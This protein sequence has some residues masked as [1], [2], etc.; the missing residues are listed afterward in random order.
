MLRGVTIKLLFRLG[1]L[2]ISY[3]TASVIR[4]PSTFTRI[5]RWSI[6]WLELER[7]LRFTSLLVFKC[8]E[9]KL[10]LFLLIFITFRRFMKLDGEK[11]DLLLQNG[12][13]FI[14]FSFFVAQLPFKE[15][16]L[17][18]FLERARL[19][20]SIYWRRKILPVFSYA[21]ILWI[22]RH[23]NE[24]LCLIRENQRST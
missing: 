24:P 21:L 10:V 15:D 1:R 6:G 22:T 2:L 7:V 19:V 4:Y 16:Y 13:L 14:K 9:H 5:I 3:R 8:L 17:L 18:M 23:S 20:E 12:F 11:F